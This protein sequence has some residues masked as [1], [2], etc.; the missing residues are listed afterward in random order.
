[1]PESGPKAK[2][3]FD[4]RAGHP[5]LSTFCASTPSPL[6]GASEKSSRESGRSLL[7][8][9]EHDI[10]FFFRNLDFRE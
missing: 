8:F 9:R 1:M 5:P 4:K 6:L 3:V 7:D 10:I 2:G